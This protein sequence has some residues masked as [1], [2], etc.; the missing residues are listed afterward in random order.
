M[1]R[2]TLYVGPPVR[3]ASLLTE[4]SHSLIHQSFDARE[5]KEPLNGDGFGM[6]WYAPRLTPEPARFRSVT[7]AW[8]DP[9]VA[10]L[11]KV[12]TSPC[13]MAHVRAATV[14]SGV[15]IANTHPFTH[16]RYVLMHNGHV[17][18]IHAVRRRLLATLSDDAFDVVRGTTDSELLFATFVDEM[19]KN[20]HPIPDHIDIS[21]DL[22]QWLT[23][24]LTRVLALV[25]E[26]GE[27]DPSFLNVAVTDGSVAAV[28]RFCDDPQ[29]KP[30]SLY[31]L[32]GEIYEPAGRQFQERRKTDDEGVPVLVSSERLTDD[33]RWEAVPANHIV[34]VDRWRPPRVLPLHLDGTLALEES[35]S[36]L[37]R[38]L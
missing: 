37:V 33:E 13:I 21:L 34:V 28:T 32:R 11:A 20:G 14:G 30:E 5:R 31:V 8:N 26:F 2:F 19:L 15:T 9:N 16:G 23:R 3:L 6:A 24:A 4:P 18:A 29:Q 1:C 35:A 12:V 17:G 22:A 38:P 36:S 25:R 10:S 27:G 7:P